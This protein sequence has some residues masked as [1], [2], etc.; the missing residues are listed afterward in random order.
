MFKVALTGNIASGK[1][2]VVEVWRERGAWVIDADELARRAVEP[3]CPAL[4]RIAERWGPAVL[5]NSGEL[6]RAALREIVFRDPAQRAALEAIVHPEVARLRDAELARAAEQGERVVVADIPL[7][8]EAEL[9]GKFDLVVLV[10]APKAVRLD[11]IVRR[12]GL[13]PEAARRMISA[14]MPARRKRQ[15]SDLVI[16][17][18]GTLEELRAAAERAWV[19]V[20]RRAGEASR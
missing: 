5:T 1:S 4:R 11:R 9:E 15:R 3:G 8:F 13:E 19:E 10:D 17:N 14:Q 2:S 6:D 7:L 18:T 16:D 20:L 12:R